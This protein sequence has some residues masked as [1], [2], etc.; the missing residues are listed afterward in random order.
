MCDVCNQAHTKLFGK[1]G[2]G[3]KKQKKKSPLPSTGGPPQLTIQNKR[4]S[5]SKG[6]LTSRKKKVFDP[7][8]GCDHTPLRMGLMCVC[9]T[10]ICAFLFTFGVC[11]YPLDSNTIRALVFGRHHFSAPFLHHYGKAHGSLLSG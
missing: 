8:R 9:C 7:K 11:L 1:G 6:G 2:G 3:C 4:S 10:G 5:L